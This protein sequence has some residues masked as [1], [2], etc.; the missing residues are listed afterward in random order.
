MAVTKSPL[1]T[2]KLAA[3]LLLGGP[4]EELL[5]T[6]DVDAEPPPPAPVECAADPA[7]ARCEGEGQIV[8]KGEVIACE[9]T[10]RV[11]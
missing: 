6:H 5:S 8:R 11:T 10:R 3:S 2:M 4:V 9:C 1:E 7:C